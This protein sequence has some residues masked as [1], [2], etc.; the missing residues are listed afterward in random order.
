MHVPMSN[1]LR[2]KIKMYIKNHIDIS[3]LIKDVSIKGE[4]LSRAIIK[5]FDRADDDISRC[6]LCE[7]VIGED[8][9]I[10]NLNRIVARNINGQ[11]LV[12][13]G[14]VWLRRADVRNSN[15][16]GAFMPQLD[17]RFSDLRG[18]DF[19]GAIFNFGSDKG[20]GAILGED[21]F[22]D[23]AKQWGLEIKVIKG[24][25]NKRNVRG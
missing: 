6:N 4:D 25:E 24:K 5:N 19:C 16:K 3:S 14:T 17:Y 8:G 2:K 23:F 12:F 22:K 21:F 20:V 15:F 1:E 9:K 18:C 13:K 11:R 10:T 7:A